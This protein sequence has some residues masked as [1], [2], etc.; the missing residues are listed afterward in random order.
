LQFS[1][2]SLSTSLNTSESVH[3]LFHY[4]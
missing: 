2:F 4:F 1:Q 3:T